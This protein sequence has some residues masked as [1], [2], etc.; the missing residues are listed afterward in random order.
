MRPSPRTQ[1]PHH[2]IKR[3][4]RSIRLM[5]GKPQEPQEFVE[6]ISASADS[7]QGAG[8][9]LENKI[10]GRMPAGYGHEYVSDAE[11]RSNIFSGMYEIYVKV[12]FFKLH[13]H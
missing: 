10:L 3:R 7:V 13:K 9:E 5:E 2:F 6:V 4:P 11:C 8:I 1:E 12:R